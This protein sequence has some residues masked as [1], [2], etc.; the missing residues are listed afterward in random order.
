MQLVHFILLYSLGCTANI[1]IISHSFLGEKIVTVTASIQLYYQPPA[2]VYKY[3][4]HTVLALSRQIRSNKQTSTLVYV[5]HC[6]SSAER[7]RRPIIAGPS[8]S[9]PQL[10]RS[11]IARAHDGTIRIRRLRPE[12]Y[13]GE[14]SWVGF[15]SGDHEEG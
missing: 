9:I 1:I 2:P 14:I 5:L 10:D 3:A 7:Y 6:T 11:H 4:S 15:F 13:D 8:Y 12:A